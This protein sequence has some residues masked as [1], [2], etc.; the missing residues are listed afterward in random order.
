[1]KGSGKLRER[2]SQARVALGAG[3]FD[4]AFALCNDPP[5]SSGQSDLSLLT[6]PA[7][8]TPSSLE[9]DR[10]LLG[11]YALFGLEHVHQAADWV[12]DYGRIRPDA[13][14][15]YMQALLHLHAREPDQALLKWTRI[16]Q[17]YPSETLADRLIEKLRVGEA[18]LQ[19]DILTRGALWE[20]LP[21]VG[22][23]TASNAEASS[24][25]VEG[26][27]PYRSSGS[28]RLLLAS[29]WP[30]ARRFALVFAIGVLAAG[31]VGVLA[32]RFGPGLVSWWGRPDP[33]RH[34]ERTLPGP[35]EG[36]SV[37]PVEKMEGGPA[38][39]VYSSRDEVALDL[40]RAR[41]LIVEGHANQARRLLARIELSNASF[42]LKERARLLRDMIPAVSRED[43]R[44]PLSRAE[45][46]RHAAEYGGGEVLWRGRVARGPKLRHPG[47]LLE[48]T[49]GDPGVSVELP[50]EGALSRSP[51]A[52][53]VWEVYGMFVG[54]DEH[55]RL[56]VR[57]RQL[58]QLGRLPAK[59][60]PESHAPGAGPPER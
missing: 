35:P 29:L 18:G 51:T 54:R 10:L 47:F 46:A 25:A 38:P 4:E 17:D 16:L 27:R 39:N 49:D 20:F 37:T 44:D 1:M 26:S 22:E 13:S 12:G 8:A 42:E 52:G 2:L 34:L 50:A 24:H 21:P 9:A 11:A 43:F 55:G 30:S 28:S 59:G 14:F 3:A 33:Y 6:A 45:A 40:R 48:P 57:A 23:R 32:A 41:S 58:R 56:T 15:L 7:S 36:G 5:R 53:Q 31:L 19:R 60:P